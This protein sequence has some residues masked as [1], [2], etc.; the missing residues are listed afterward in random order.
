MKKIDTQYISEKKADL[1]EIKYIVDNLF[2]VDSEEWLCLYDTSEKNPN[3]VQI[4]SDI[5]YFEDDALNF[6]TQVLQIPLDNIDEIEGIYLAE[7]R[8]YKDKA[9]FRHYRAFFLDADVVYSYFETY[10]N[11]E[12]INV[13]GWYDVTEEF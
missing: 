6:L 10:I 5:E 7:C 1:D 12:A 4:H 11:D 9:N 13:E 2:T 8:K 3:Y